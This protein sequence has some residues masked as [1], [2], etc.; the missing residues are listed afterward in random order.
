MI[1][2]SFRILVQKYMNGRKSY[3]LKKCQNSDILHIKLKIRL[4]QS[5]SSMQIRSAWEWYHWKGLEKALKRTSAAIGF[6]FFNFNLEYLK[7]LQ[8]FSSASYKNPSN[9]SISSTDGLYGHKPQTTI[10]ST[11]PGPKMQESQQLFFGGRL[12]TIPTARNINQSSGALWRI[13]SSDKSAPANRKKGFY[14][15]R[16]PK[17]QEVEGIIVSSGSELWGLFKYSRSN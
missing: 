8:T 2:L 7:N 16:V 9:P 3:I 15:N 4:K 5:V 11:K 6:W 12:W 1:N 10:F 14:T 13:F 17:K